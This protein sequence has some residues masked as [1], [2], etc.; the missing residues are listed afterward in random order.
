MIK[1]CLYVLN[2][3][4]GHVIISVSYSHANIDY[5]LLMIFN[6]VGKERAGVTQL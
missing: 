6:V 1:C 2:K 3:S 4:V 5:I